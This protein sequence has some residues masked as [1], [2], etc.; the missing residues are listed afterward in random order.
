MEQQTVLSV[1]GLVKKFGNDTILKGIDLDVK[2]AKWLLC[3]APVAAVK[4]RFFAV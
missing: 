4:A 2:K 1:K 3:L